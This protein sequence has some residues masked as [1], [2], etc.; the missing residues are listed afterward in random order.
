MHMLGDAMYNPQ[1][2]DVTLGKSAS[3]SQSAWLNVHWW[4]PGQLILPRFHP[5]F[6]FAKTLQHNLKLVQAYGSRHALG[7]PLSV[8]VSRKSIIGMRIDC[9][10]GQRLHGGR[11]WAAL[12]S[13]K[14]CVYCGSTNAET[15]DVVR[16]IEPGNEPNT[17][18]AA[19]ISKKI[20]MMA[21]WSRR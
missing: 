17:D 1:Y 11:R 16:M 7:R 8:G 2:Q 3:F 10:A 14:A 18:G 5:G 12:A 19:A 4:Y 13:V 15:V 20:L 6:G 21:S 9:P